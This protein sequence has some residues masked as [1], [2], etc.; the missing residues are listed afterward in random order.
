MNPYRVH[1][2]PWPIY[3]G[4]PHAI[5]RQIHEAHCRNSRERPLAGRAFSLH[6]TPRSQPT[7]WLAIVSHTSSS[8]GSL[9]M[10]RSIA[11]AFA[12]LEQ[13]QTSCVSPILTSA[14][15]AVWQNSILEVTQGQIL[16]QSP[17]DAT[18]SGGICMGVD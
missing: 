6:P 16:S 10:G 9:I 13:R 1:L 11:S 12:T 18:D 3:Q 7:S 5:V 17:T 4:Y 8:M 14:F 2:F 15:F